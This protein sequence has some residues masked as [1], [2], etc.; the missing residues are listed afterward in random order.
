V[1]P[2]AVPAGYQGV[3]GLAVERRVPDRAHEEHVG[4]GVAAVPFPPGVEVHVD[5][6]D[7]FGSDRDDPGFVAFTEDP[8][9]GGAL[10]GLD[11][12]DGHGRGLGDAHAGPGE[13][14]EEGAVPLRPGLPGAGVG[15]GGGE[16]DALQ[17]GV[18]EGP[19]GPTPAAWARAG[20]R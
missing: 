20:W 17:F 14:G 12:G 10:G 19:W 16:C 8:Q 15:A 13:D 4:G 7:D 1:T 9:A 3:Q 18:L 2:A 5:G 6:L 11:R